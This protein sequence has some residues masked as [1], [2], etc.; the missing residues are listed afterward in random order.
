MAEEKKLTV[1][2]KNYLA[3][4]IDAI[5]IEKKREIESEYKNLLNKTAYGY[6]YDLE[7]VKAVVS[8]EIDLKTDSVRAVFEQK[9]A[10]YEKRVNSGDRYCGGLN[11]TVADFIDKASAEKFF[12]KKKKIADELNVQRNERK[13]KVT[14]EATKVKDKIILEG[15]KVAIELLDKF[16]EM[17]F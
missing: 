17:K 12:D 15:S 2:Q 1:V 8:G 13:R 16:A 9:L 7:R 11:V 10:D 6:N 4:R 5:A 3:K 14:E